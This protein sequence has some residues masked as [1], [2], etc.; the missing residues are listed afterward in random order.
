M[1]EK[2]FTILIGPFSVTVFLFGIS[3]GI[4]LGRWLGS[5][6]LFYSSLF[7]IIGAVTGFITVGIFF[8]FAQ[9]GTL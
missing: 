1:N 3:S 8:Y 7:T 9:K 5:D 4:F 2:K 6:S